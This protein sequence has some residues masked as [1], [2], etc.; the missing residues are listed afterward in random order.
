MNKIKIIIGEQVF[1]KIGSSWFVILLVFHSYGC[2]TKKDSK[3][4][5]LVSSLITSA[6]TQG[7]SDCVYCGD[8]Q[9]F[10]GSCSCYT[11]VA[12]GSCP[13]VNTGPFKNNSYKVSCSALTQIGTWVTDD[14]GV[15]SCNYRTCP[16]DAYQAAFGKDT[17]TP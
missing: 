15:R 6:L 9:V 14:S 17:N 2:E 13:G 16:P 4:K 8:K 5:I 12:V 10:R 1:R 3:E 11:Q 7:T